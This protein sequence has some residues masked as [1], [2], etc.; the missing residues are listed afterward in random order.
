MTEASEIAEGDCLHSWLSQSS[1]M[2]AKVFDG[3]FLGNAGTSMNAE[4]LRNNRITKLINVAG[5]DVDNIKEGDGFTYETYKWQDHPDY[6]V[7]PDMENDRSLISIVT[8]IDSTLR[9]GLSILVFSLNG[10]SRSIFAVCA[11]LMYKYHWGFEKCYDFILSKKDDV[12]MNH[13]FVSQL[14]ALE[15][16]LLSRRNEWLQKEN[17]NLDGKDTVII[18]RE[19][20]RL[21]EWDPLYLITSPTSSSYSRSDPSS[22]IVLIKIEASTGTGFNVDERGDELILI[23]TYLNSKNTITCLPEV[24]EESANIQKTFKVKFNPVRQIKMIEIYSS[25]TNFDDD[26]DDNDDDDAAE[27]HLK[28]RYDSKWATMDL[29][30]YESSIRQTTDLN[31]IKTKYIKNTT[32]SKTTSSLNLL[33][34]STTLSSD[35]TEST[36]DANVKT[37]RPSLTRTS[38]S[39]GSSRNRLILTL[40]NAETTRETSIENSPLLLS[41]KHKT[42]ISNDEFSRFAEWKERK[43]RG[44]SSQSTT[45]RASFSE[46]TVRTVSP[47]STTSISND[48]FSRFAEWKERRRLLDLGASSDSSIPQSPQRTS[49][50]TKTTRTTTYNKDYALSGS[51]VTNM[52]FTEWQER[53]KKKKDTGITDSEST[54]R[55]KSLSFSEWKE[56]RRS[57]EDTYSISPYN[58][59]HT[60]ATTRDSSMSY[61]EWKAGRKKGNRSASFDEHDVKDQMNSKVRTSR[62]SFNVNTPRAGSDESSSFADFRERRRKRDAIHEEITR[63]SS[64]SSNINSSISTS[65]N[66][67]AREATVGRAGR[68]PRNVE[69]QSSSVHTHHIHTTYYLD[70]DR[71]GGDSNGS[72][73]NHVHDITHHTGTKLYSTRTAADENSSFG[74]WKERRRRGERS[75]S[76]DENDSNISGRTTTVTRTSFNVNAPREGSDASTSFAEYREKRRRANMLQ[77]AISDSNT[78]NTTNVIKT[79]NI[80]DENTSFADW[81][82]RRRRQNELQNQSTNETFAD[83]SSTTIHNHY[84]INVNDGNDNDG[85][86]HNPTTTST[87]TK[88]TV[89]SS[90]NA[91][92]PF[93]KGDRLKDNADR[94]SFSDKIALFNDK[95]SYYSAQK[96]LEKCK[97]SEKKVYLTFVKKDPVVEESKKTL[98][99]DLKNDTTTVQTSANIDDA[100]TSQAS[101]KF[102]VRTQERACVRAPTRFSITSSRRSSLVTTGNEDGEPFCYEKLIASLNQSET[103]AENKRN[104]ARVVSAENR[105]LNLMQDIQVN[106]ASEAVKNQDKQDNHQII[107]TSSYEINSNTRNYSTHLSMNT[108]VA[109]EVSENEIS[110]PDSDDDVFS[111]DRVAIIPSQSVVRS[112][113]NITITS[114]NKDINVPPEKVEVAEVQK[115]ERKNIRMSLHSLSY[116]RDTPIMDIN[117]INHNVPSGDKDTIEAERIE[118]ENNKLACS[119]AEAAEAALMVRKLQEIEDLDKEREKEKAYRK[120]QRQ[121]HQQ[122]QKKHEEA[123]LKKQQQQEERLTIAMVENKEYD[124]FT[125]PF[126]DS[127]EKESNPVVE[128]FSRGSRSI[129]NLWDEADNGNENINYSILS[130]NSMKMVRPVSLITPKKMELPVKGLIPVLVPAL[131]PVPVPVVIVKREPILLGACM[132]PV[133][134]VKVREPAPKMAKPLGYGSGAKLIIIDGAEP[135][136]EPIVVAPVAT[137]PVPTPAAV[138]VKVPIDTATIASK[139]SVQAVFKKRETA[140]VVKAVTVAPVVVPV[141]VPA[142]A[143]VPV[144]VPVPVTVVKVDP[145]LVVKAAIVTPVPVPV[146]APVVIKKAET[147]VVVVD[148]ASATKVPTAESIAY[149]EVTTKHLDIG[150][151]KGFFKVFQDAGGD[152][153]FSVLSPKN[154]KDSSESTPKVAAQ[155]DSSRAHKDISLLKSVID[156]VVY[157]DLTE[158]IPLT[159]VVKQISVPLYSL[160]LPSEADSVR[161]LSYTTGYVS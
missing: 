100:G 116:R 14:Q 55:V 72:S 92:K 17:H 62:A 128:E 105:L 39:L 161:K 63:G 124:L 61:S 18:K 74:A 28:A 84:D 59:T 8:F 66:T 109:N 93:G 50:T 98:T 4:F 27:G 141:S 11:Y 68:P 96:E 106:D 6:P 118:A 42:S 70:S 47:K 67:N 30:N 119:A 16:R 53:K 160:S 64:S 157:S 115:C 48:E 45:P 140:V 12:Q 95:V 127:D 49:T 83:N 43:L 139:E 33:H 9:S 94:L 91:I 3:F 103:E 132:D 117:T 120:A 23:N 22:D 89:T 46:N 31:A 7:F 131:A 69:N 114:T 24:D 51:N 104:S 147:V 25:K 77:G 26:D 75:H 110:D 29:N 37:P 90:M 108:V 82:E 129:R 41:N 122:Q 54:D 13:G 138:V 149:K 159:P 5:G 134:I 88:T 60:T 136:Y 126:L 146:P 121:Y 154:S 78:S 15:K 76:F 85:T 1:V 153:D 150:K 151:D 79:Q 65:I 35:C 155:L 36:V 143:T 2:A 148:K 137:A 135:E 56:R 144:P 38:S 97:I 58:S 123:E 71:V 145:V 142:L 102:P 19:N 34:S 113:S 111:M 80:S 130:D 152:D 20:E 10:L 40:E 57:G 125:D 133:P 112:P 158:D 44:E 21:K 101:L 32:E 86:Q 99:T 81:R 87:H 52:S 107:N 156:D 73:T